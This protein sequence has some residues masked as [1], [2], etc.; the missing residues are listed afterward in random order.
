MEL[1]FVLPEIAKAQR[2]AGDLVA[3]RA[4]LDLATKV[5]ESL[6]EFSKIQ[7]L[8]RL[9]EGREPQREKHEVG[10][11]VRCEL[12]AAIALERIAMGDRDEARVLLQRSVAAIQSQKD[13]LNVMAL[14]N[15]APKLFKVG[16]QE[17]ARAMIDQAR[18]AVTEL[19]DPE[20]RDGAMVEIAE[21]LAEIGDLDGALGLTRDLGKHGSRSALRGIISSLADAHPRGW[22]GDMYGIKRMIGAGSIQL[23]ERS[24]ARRDLPKIA[25]VVRGIPDPLL[26]AHPI[27]DR[28]PASQGG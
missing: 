11:L 17:Q 16:E 22:G 15:F 20:A 24:S 12:L 2:Q 19:T 26:Q 25:K 27:D 21:S 8:Q 1:F 28:S 7:E 5:V 6:K 3:A 9:R 13:G 14:T 23:K 10:P 4:S 18:R